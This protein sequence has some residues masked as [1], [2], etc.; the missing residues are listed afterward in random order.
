M[1]TLP[2]LLL[3]KNKTIAL[4][5]VAHKTKLFNFFYSST[6]FTDFKNNH[7]FKRLS[8]SPSQVKAAIYLFLSR[9]SCQTCIRKFS[10]QTLHPDLNPITNYQPPRLNTT[11]KQHTKMTTETETETPSTIPRMLATTFFSIIIL[12]ISDLTPPYMKGYLM[13]LL[14]RAI[15]LEQLILY[16]IDILFWMSVIIYTSCMKP[17]Y[18]KLARFFDSIGAY[19]A[20]CEFVYKSLELAEQEM[21]EVGGLSGCLIF[22]ES[23]LV[24]PYIASKDT[25]SSAVFETPAAPIT[26]W[27]EP[28]NPG[29]T[30][31]ETPTSSM[32]HPPS[33][34][35]T[36]SKETT[37]E[38]TPFKIEEKSPLDENTTDIDPLYVEYLPTPPTI[39]H[40]PLKWHC[41]GKYLD[42]TPI[43]ASRNQNADTTA[44]PTTS[45]KA[46][47][48]SEKET[49][50]TTLESHEERGNGEEL[51]ISD[52]FSLA[53]NSSFISTSLEDTFGA[54]AAR[55]E[56]Y[57]PLLLEDMTPPPSPTPT[58][59]RLGKKC[60]S[61]QNEKNVSI[62][63]TNTNTNKG[64]FLEDEDT[65]MQEV[66]WT[67]SRY[68]S[69]A[70]D[71]WGTTPEPIN[72]DEMVV[73]VSSSW[74]KD[75]NISLY[76][77][78][79]LD[80]VSEEDFLRITNAWAAGLLEV[81]ERKLSGVA[82]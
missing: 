8:L 41:G 16:R 19:I 61:S 45:K 1:A 55:R 30:M 2:F 62:P 25:D 34:P 59:T 75:Q 11:T 78:D 46:A 67:N 48:P 37:R 4:G 26:P 3:E 20:M 69:D 5:F 50:P 27:L 22:T 12:L 60:T 44:S 52:L 73:A 42:G 74:S 63:H 79:D 51:D 40:R 9:P 66:P 47:T 56:K 36:P 80:G 18:D 7:Q 32:E 35:I 77:R 31:E 29:L 43:L 82:L 14:P 65:I 15:P 72:K 68:I 17:Y 39:R 10:K 28:G 81:C 38:Y 53:S 57:S 54:R 49:S 58:P 13:I 6:R 70:M 33:S 71:S 24:A 23:E 76:D 21:S 64:T